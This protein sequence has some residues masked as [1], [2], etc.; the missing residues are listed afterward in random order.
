MPTFTVLNQANRQGVT[1]TGSATI[2][3]SPPESLIA[4]I[5]IALADME[6]L[7]MAVSLDAEVSADA[8]VN[9]V[10][11][12]RG[13]WAGGPQD[14]KNNVT[15]Q[16]RLLVDGLPNHANKLLRGVLTNSPKTPIGLSVTV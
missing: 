1:T 8:G 6:D 11:I 10:R 3:A 13:S 16:W 15:P 14:Q 9:W 12:A 2:P 4:T 7:T 5:L